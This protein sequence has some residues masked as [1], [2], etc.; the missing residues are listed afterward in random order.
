PSGDVPPLQGTGIVLVGGDHNV[1]T[2]NQVAGNIGTQAF[3]GGIV[4]V[5][6]APPRGATEGLPA[7]FNTVTNN[8]LSANSPDDLIDA[9][10]SATNTFRHNQCG[11]SVP[12][13]LCSS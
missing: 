3:S 10:G 9:S 6:G 1:I 4:L 2:R 5:R 11:S 12:A 8:V 13:G 7:A